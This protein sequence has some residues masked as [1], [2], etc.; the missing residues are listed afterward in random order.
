MK[1]FEALLVEGTSEYLV[2]CYSVFPVS[3]IDS[4]YRHML[5][6]YPEGDYFKLHESQWPYAILLSEVHLDEI[7]NIP[8][9]AVKLMLRSFDIGK[10]KAAICMLDGAFYDYNDVFSPDISDQ[11]YAFSINPNEP[12]TAIDNVVRLSN[13]WKSIIAK[14]RSLVQCGNT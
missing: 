12:I 14:Q 13:E 6:R 4:V 1:L 11:I 2:L 5:D 9:T 7:M 3:E 10:C 8:Q